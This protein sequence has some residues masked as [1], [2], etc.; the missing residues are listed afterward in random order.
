MLVEEFKREEEMQPINALGVEF[1]KKML[2]NFASN[3]DDASNKTP[4]NS[5]PVPLSN[6]LN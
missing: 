4:E 6:I 1:M 2:P 5:T 3:K